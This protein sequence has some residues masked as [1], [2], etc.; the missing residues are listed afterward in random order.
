MSYVQRLVRSGHHI[1]QADTF[2]VIHADREFSPD[3]RHPHGPLGETADLVALP[4]GE[5]IERTVE[6]KEGRADRVEWNLDGLD[7]DKTHEDTNGER[8][9]AE[10]GLEFLRDA[11]R[12]RGV[13]YL[14]Q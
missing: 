13:F 3:E 9:E 12:H 6:H 11:V 4:R 10:L 14:Y 2:F 5:V 1:V 8:A 7:E